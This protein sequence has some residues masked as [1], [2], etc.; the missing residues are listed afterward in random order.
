MTARRGRRGPGDA[1]HVR[2]SADV[3]RLGR[4]DAAMLIGRL[5]IEID[6]T[7]GVIKVAAKL[8]AVHTAG[9]VAQRVAELVVRVTSRCA[10]SQR[11]L[12]I[13][14]AQSA[15]IDVLVGTEAEVAVAAFAPRAI[16][17]APQAEAAARI[18]RAVHLQSDLASEQLTLV[19]QG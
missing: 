8:P 4:A 11:A 7:G 17:A 13:V 2:D 6:R 5:Q 19:V 16:A 3:D 12:P 15:A 9:A 10:D 14:E 1:R 18:G